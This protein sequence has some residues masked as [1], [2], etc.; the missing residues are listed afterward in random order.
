[1]LPGGAV[2][3]AED[4]S[5]AREHFSKNTY[6]YIFHSIFRPL[7][8]YIY[9]IIRHLLSHLCGTFFLDAIKFGQKFCG[10]VF[11]FTVRI[12]VLRPRRRSNTISTTHFRNFCGANI[13]GK[14]EIRDVSE[15]KHTP[16]SSSKRVVNRSGEKIRLS[17]TQR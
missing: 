8:I 7:T 2:I 14:R 15:E 17:Q 5:L 16:I 9:I 11:F 12:I 4:T 10:V 13:L 3:T 6:I 1:M